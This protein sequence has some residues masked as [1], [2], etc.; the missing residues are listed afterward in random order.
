LRN[1][2]FV[3]PLLV[4]CLGA[5]AL[6]G[7]GSFNG[8]WSGEIA[9]ADGDKRPATFF[10]KQ[11][12]DVLS[13]AM[14]LNFRMQNFTEGKVTGDEATWVIVTRPGGRERRVEYHARLSGGEIHVTLPGPPNQPA[15]EVTAKKDSDDPTPVGPFA[16]LPKP[17]LP[18]IH[19]LPDNGLARTP[20]MGWNSWNH[21]HGRVEDKVVREI[22]D[23]MVSSGMKDAGYIY[24]NIDDTWEAGRDAN[25]NI[26]TNKK[27]PDMKAL[28]DYV[29][30]KGLKLGIYSSPGPKTCAGYEGSYLHESQDA[31]TFA[32]WGID[33]LKYDWCSAN[34]V[35]KP[36]DMQAAYQK[37]GEALRASG[38]AIVYSLCQYGLEKV[39]T[40]GPAVGGNLWRTTGDIGDNWRSMT[41]IGFDKQG[42]LEKYAAPGHWNDP[43]MLEIG[44]GN[45]DEV[46]Y[47]THMSLWAMLAAP[48]LAGNDI[49]SMPDETKQILMN[50]E[51]IAIDQ[52]KLG[53]QGF[54]V[55][56]DGHTE[57]WAKPLEGGDLAVAMFNR[58]D[59]PELM[60]AKWSELG[61]TGKHSTRDVWAHA[62][63]GK[64]KDLFEAEV[65]AHG[66]VM[67]R[68]SK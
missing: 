1:N 58:G 28:A 49:R 38:R 65:S 20:P 41:N 35:M 39:E 27:F 56:K 11:S 46:E 50:R 61:L 16:N 67:I 7:Q 17:D 26:Q 6:L 14:T 43:D 55:S 54:R 19:P 44:N 3:K 32:A 48:L 60:F 64:I 22:A 23:A 34:Q 59:K 45:M 4:F 2:V 33:Y 36:T 9:N 40:W 47:K 62:E 12:G 53:R 8:R 37:M 29:H 51:V 18:A 15:T 42:G 24:V 25:G 68:V 31:K 52:D 66:V 5:S 57:I 21:F 13:G 30:S 10:L 63:R